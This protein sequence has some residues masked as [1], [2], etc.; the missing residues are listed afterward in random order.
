[1][2]DLVILLTDSFLNVLEIKDTTE[3]LLHTWPANWQWGQ[4]VHK[5]DDFNFP[6]VNFQPHLHRV[7]IS[8]F[9]MVEIAIFSLSLMA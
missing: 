6:I 1:M 7:Y 4:I 3:N 8:L 2:G 9:S 5:W